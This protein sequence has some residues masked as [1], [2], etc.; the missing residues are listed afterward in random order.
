MARRLRVGVIFGGRSGEHD[1]SLRSAQ[2]I[3]NALE[4][5]RFDLVPI[6][7]TRQGRWLTGGD[8]LL[9]LAANSALPLPGVTLDRQNSSHLPENVEDQ[10]LDPTDSEWAS[11]VDVLFPVLHGP[12][13]EDGTVQ[14]MLELSNIPYVGS[15]VLASSLAMDKIVS[16]QIF[17][18]L[19]LPVAPWIWVLRRDWERDPDAISARI[20]A[21]L[22]YPCFVK[23][24]NLGSSVGISKVR[25]QGE[26]ANAMAEAAHHDRKILIE[27]GLNARELEVSVL[28]N[29]D[30]VTSVVGEIVPSNEF[31]DYHAKYVD[32]RSELLIPA[33]IDPEISEEVRRM[34]VEAFKAIDGAGMAR[35]DFFLERETGAIYLN[36]INTIPGFTAISM[37][38]KLWEASGLPFQELVA[39]LIELA[40]ERHRERGEPQS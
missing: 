26:L 37:Y 11:G 10:S 30:P 25:H 39:R 5:D 18:Q 1:V 14:G 13:G 20:E 12:F 3:M 28:G 6:G 2:A 40:V 32:D 34:A 36:E 27:Q 24:A 4:S 23:P 38:P 8:P 29:D 33:P 21:E 17:T 15:G 22:G 16:K 9:R 7:I 35:V 19:G 31:Y